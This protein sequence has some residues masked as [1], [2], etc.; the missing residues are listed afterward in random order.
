MVPKRLP[1]VQTASAQPDEDRLDLVGPG[2]GGEVEVGVGVDP[3]EDGVAHDPADEVQAGA[4]GREP[5]GEGRRL[6]QERGEAVRDH[7]GSD[8]WGGP[9]RPSPAT[10]R[11]WAASTTLRPGPPLVTGSG[12]RGSP[13]SEVTQAVVQSARASRS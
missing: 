3:A 9:G 10:W 13:A 12:R 8:Y 6:G 2:V 1:W 4:G 7:G 5:F 11:A